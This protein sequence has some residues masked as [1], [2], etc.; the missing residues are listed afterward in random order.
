MKKNIHTET[1]KKIAELMQEIKSLN[2]ELDYCRNMNEILRTNYDQVNSERINYRRIIKYHSLLMVLAN[3]DI[4]QKSGAWYAYEGNKIGQGRENA[5]QYLS[6]HP[7]VFDEVVR[8]VRVH[9]GLE[10]GE[11]AGQGQAPGLEQDR[12]ESTAAAGGIGSDAGEGSK[13]DL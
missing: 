13:E 2:T 1:D 11:D 9:F 5:K 3:L 7:E 8:K 4:I 6:E 10:Q 12:D